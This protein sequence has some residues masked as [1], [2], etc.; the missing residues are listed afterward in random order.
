LGGC[1]EVRGTYDGGS[2]I[3]V[4]GVGN[5][6]TRVINADRT[7]TITVPGVKGNEGFWDEFSKSNDYRVA[8]V[9]GG[10]YNLL[11]INNVDTSI[12]ASPT[13]EE[14]LDTEVN[15]NVAIKW[16]DRNNMKSSDVPTGIFN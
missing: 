9:V 4:P 5:Q 12:F 7:M 14:G 13:V 3:D 16:K 15:W 6:D 11:L 8:I 1:Q 10:D 2:P